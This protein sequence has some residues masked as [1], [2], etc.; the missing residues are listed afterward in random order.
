MTPGTHEFLARIKSLFGKR[1]MDR[2]MAEELEFHQTLLREKFE[3]QGMPPAAAA[4]AAR[5]TFGNTSRWHERL[6]EQWQFKPLETF[7]RDLT[8][9]ARAHKKSPGFLAVAL[10]TL[11]LGV[12]ANTAVFSMINALL[13]RP[14]SVPHSEQLAIL[15]MEDGG[16]QPKYVFCTPFFRGLEKRRDIFANVFAY[17]PDV[18]PVQGRSGNENIHGMLVSGQFF[19]ALQTT[20][21]MGRYLTPA[22]DQSGGNPDGLAVVISESFW[23]SW[24]DRAPDVVGRELIIANVPFTVVGVM[25]KQFIGADPTQKPDVFVPLSADP[26]IDSPRNHIDAGIHAWWINVM[27][28]LQPGVSLQQANAALL[29]VSSPILHE[30]TSDVSYLAS[31]EKGHFRFAA[32]SGSRGFTYA[33]LLFR[34]PLL[35]MFSM[36]GGILL[37][38]CLNLTSLLM[39]RAAARER[40]LATRLA[41]GATRRDLIQQLLMESLLIAIA[42][43]ALGLVLAPIVSHSVTTMLTRGNIAT[44]A[45]LDTSL[46]IR[47]FLFAAL[48]AITATILIGLLPA[49]QVTGGNLNEHIKEGQHP[50]K[51]LERHKLLPRV[52]MASEVALALLLVTGAGLLT[53]SLVRLYKSGAGLDPTGLVNITFSMDK[54]QIEG[55]QLMQLYQ[56]LGDGLSHQPGVKSASFEFIIPLSHRG[57]NDGFSAPGGNSHLLWLNSVGPRYFET[58][59]IPLFAGREFMWSDTKASGPKIILNQSAAKLLFPDRDALGQQVISKFEKTAYEVVA[60]VGDA[61]YRDMRSP[62]PAAGYVPIMQDPQKKPSLTAVLRVEGPQAPL[63]NAARTLAARLA[64]TIPPPVFSTMDEIVNNSIGAERMM[65]SLALFFAACALLVTAIGLYG[66]LAYTTAR[67]TNEIGIRMALGAQRSRVMAM[68]FRQNAVIAI[69]GSAAGL[70]AAVLASRALAS[71][72]YETSPRDP[73]VFVG[74]VAAL[75]AIASAASL[76]P[77]LRAARIEPSA[78]IRCE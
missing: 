49:L 73:W 50:N 15:S 12:G 9:A 40:E 74:S 65:A 23:E 11:A 58:M 52:L 53:T 6:R 30:A 1:R 43:T 51:A 39:A 25:P 20:P 17:N 76:L 27:A 41:L 72:L 31:E 29:T 63:A 71:F 69:I 22:D 2:E 78:A 61:K 42:G 64:P 60:V 19:T 70:I 21:R 32:E 3:R 5:K 7:V 67:R 44:G 54:Q 62:A 57:W 77:A 66:T 46:D 10:L 24:F 55:D 18:M 35:A 13:L 8:F 16:P 33:R 26:I 28:R 34:K 48:L 4:Q 68:I 38:A 59:R 75:T 36:C 45:A 37:L 14:L 56:Q 47:V